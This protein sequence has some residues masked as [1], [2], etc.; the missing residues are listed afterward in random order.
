MRQSYDIDGS[1]LVIMEHYVVFSRRQPALLLGIKQE[2]NY[3]EIKFRYL[4][5]IILT[6][7]GQLR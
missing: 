7:T 1:T 4:I 6:G 2:L 5:S 3:I